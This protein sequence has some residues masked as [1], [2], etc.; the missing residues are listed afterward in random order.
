[1]KTAR[2]TTS[3]SEVAALILVYNILYNI[4]TT[5]FFDAIDRETKELPPCSIFHNN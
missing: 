3:R 5:S 1:V 2:V 4:A